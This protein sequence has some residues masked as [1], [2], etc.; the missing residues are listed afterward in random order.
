MATL[1]LACMCTYSGLPAAAADTDVFAV[2]GR[3]SRANQQ[4]QHEENGNRSCA[5][6]KSYPAHHQRE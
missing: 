6:E 5:G 2:A 4:A 1:A 3:L